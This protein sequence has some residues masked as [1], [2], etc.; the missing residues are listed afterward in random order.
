MFQ[1]DYTKP[2]DDK[3]RVAFDGDG[4]LFSDESERVYR[5]KGLDAFLQNEKDL[6]DTVLKVVKK[7]LV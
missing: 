2:S 5:E 3:L 4:V 1:T 6:E 7:L